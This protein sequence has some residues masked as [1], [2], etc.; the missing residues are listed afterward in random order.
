MYCL[1]FPLCKQLQVLCL[2]LRLTQFPSTPSVLPFSGLISHLQTQV[3]FL[4]PISKGPGDISDF[5]S[6]SVCPLRHSRILPAQDSRAQV[7][8][9]QGLKRMSPAQSPHYSMASRNQLGRNMT[10]YEY[11]R[12]GY[13][14]EMENTESCTAFLVKVPASFDLRK[15]CRLHHPQTREYLQYIPHRVVK[16]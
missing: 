11:Y 10:H 3:W 15:D 9:I 7:S 16:S 14:K 2:L 13:G 1:P 6:S 5:P 12:Y 8:T 4:M